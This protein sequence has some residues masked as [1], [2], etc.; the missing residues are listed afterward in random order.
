MVCCGQ[1]RLLFK[2]RIYTLQESPSP[3]FSSSTQL[4]HLQ[5]L[6]TSSRTLSFIAASLNTSSHLSTCVSHHSSSLVPPLWPWLLQL[7]SQSLSLNQLT[8]EVSFHILIAVFTRLISTS[9]LIQLL[10]RDTEYGCRFDHQ[11]S[12]LYTFLTPM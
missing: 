12:W 2:Y 10:T 4:P 6:P 8:M 9:L 11:S 5:P 7:L 3:L 1:S